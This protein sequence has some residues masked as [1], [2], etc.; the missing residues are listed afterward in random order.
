MKNLINYFY[1]F[2][3]SDLRNLNDS[4]IFNFNNRTYIFNKIEYDFD[5]KSFIE[6]LKT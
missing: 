6:I 2:N 4:Y 1:D 3:I 5:S